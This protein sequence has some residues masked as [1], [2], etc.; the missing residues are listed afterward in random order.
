MDLLKTTIL[1]TD[2]KKLAAEM[3]AQLVYERPHVLLVVLGRDADAE[4]LVERADR[5]AGL[6]EGHRWVVWA[7]KPEQIEE[8]VR[9]LKG[10]K[11]LVAKLPTARGFALS[12][13]DEVRDV[14]LLSEPVPDQFR[15][16]QAFARAEAT[17]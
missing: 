5:F 9:K 8:E 16:F 4:T 13:G 14:M 11:D 15:L 6:P 10:K 3:F 17:S 7:R 12:L 2:D 1:P